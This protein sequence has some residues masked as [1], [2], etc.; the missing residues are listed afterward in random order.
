SGSELHE[1]DSWYNLCMDEQQYGYR[2]WS[3]WYWKHT[4]V[5]RY[6]YHSPANKRYDNGNTQFCRLHGYANNVYNNGQCVTNGQP[7]SGQPVIM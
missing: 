7:C 1:P 3:K 5:H 4:I 6:Q 2:P